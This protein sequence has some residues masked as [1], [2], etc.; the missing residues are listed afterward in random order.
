MDQGRKWGCGGGTPTS[1][2]TLS[3]FFYQFLLGNERTV[4]QELRE[5]YVDT[6]SKIYLSYFKSYTSRLMKIQVGFGGLGDALETPGDVFWVLTPLRFVTRSTRRWP[7]RM[8]SW[9]WRTRPKK[10]SWDRGG[11]DD[12]RAE[13]LGGGGR[14]LGTHRYC[15]D[16]CYRHFCPPITFFFQALAEKPQHCLHSG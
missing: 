15:L 3:R 9:A 11:Q 10:I 14:R 7:R 5:Q 12:D 6:M 2:L 16:P 13:V 8:I 4:A 1:P